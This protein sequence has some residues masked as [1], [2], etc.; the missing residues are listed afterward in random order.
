MATK[1]VELILLIE[2][3]LFFI[4]ETTLF[5]PYSILDFSDVEQRL[6]APKKKKKLYTAEKS[7]QAKQ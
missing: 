7:K 5:A 2:E 6:T 4:R 1:M 3:T